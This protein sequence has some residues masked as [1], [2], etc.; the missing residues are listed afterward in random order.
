M[1]TPIVPAISRAID[2]AVS[3]EDK[4]WIPKVRESA[5]LPPL[6]PGGLYKFLVAVTAGDE[7]PAVKE[8]AFRVRGRAV[9]PSAALAFRN[10]TFFRS[11]EDRSPLAIAAFRPGDAVWARFDLA[12]YKIAE[13]NKFDVD[14]LVSVTG[15]AGNVL[16][17]QPEPTAEQGAPFYPK[18]YVPAEFSLNLAKDASPGEYGLTIAARDNVGAQKIEVRQVF[19]VE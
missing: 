13:G 1:G 11:D 4:D 10:F 5:E 17:T 8:V 9:E 2:S 16:Y 14:Y 3:P 18:R 7:K 12:G 15:P 6:G 19:R